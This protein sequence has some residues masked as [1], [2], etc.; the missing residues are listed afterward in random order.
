M[1]KKKY[2]IFVVQKSRIYTI[3]LY[4]VCIWR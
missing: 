1:L 3:R 4:A 2:Q